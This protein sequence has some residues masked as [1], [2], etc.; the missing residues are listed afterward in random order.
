MAGRFQIPPS[1]WDRTLLLAIGAGI[2]AII[3]VVGTAYIIH[4]SKTRG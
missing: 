1:G 2:G 3:G 4:V